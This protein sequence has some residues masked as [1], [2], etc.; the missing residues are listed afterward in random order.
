MFF[1]TSVRMKRILTALTL[2]LALAA[3]KQGGGE[4]P[5]QYRQFPQVQ[6]PSVYSEPEEIAQYVLGHWWDGFFSGDGATDSAAVLG[7]RKPEVEQALSTWLGGLESLPVADAQK[8]VGELFAKLDACQSAEPDSSLT[9]LRFSEMVERYLYDP[10]SPMRSEDLFL[11]FVRGLAESRWTREDMR[12]GYEYQARMCAINQYG[13][14][15]PD[16]AYTDARGRRHNLY[17]IKAAHTLLFFSNPGCEACK[18]ILEALQ[19]RPYIDGMIADGG[20]AVINIYI[21]KEIDKW[22]EYEP[23][24]PRSWLTGYDHLFRIR[25]EQIYDVRAIPSLYLLDAEKRVIL[26][27]APTE[28][29]IAYLDNINS[30][31]YGNNQ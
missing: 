10:N 8:L 13:Q 7:V 30:Q 12:P 27:D 29:A 16:F 17:D 19:S 6:V 26:K 23:E 9:F 24:Y 28:K 15:V 20:L 2:L 25:E 5:A 1:Q 3:C 21:D 18:E 11:P 4:K 31:Y 14:Q 22:L